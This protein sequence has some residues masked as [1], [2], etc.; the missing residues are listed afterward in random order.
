[1]RRLL[2][3]LLLALAGAVAM[4]P[5]TAQDRP[6]PV[7]K[8][9]VLGPPE[10]W[11]ARHPFPELPEAAAPDSAAV[12]PQPSLTEPFAIGEALHDP[13]RVA[14]A[15]VSALALMGIQIVADDP[16]TITIGQVPMQL[17]QSEVRALITMGVAD[18]EAQ[19]QTPDGP[20][21]FKN[22][23]TRLSRYLGNTSPERLAEM[24]SEE[25][26]RRPESLVPQLLLG[27][28]IDVDTPL[29][30]TELWLMLVDA[31]VPT[32]ASR[33]AARLGPRL[34]LARYAPQSSG[35]GAWLQPT[36]HLPGRMSYFAESQLTLRMPLLLMSTVLLT[37]GSGH[38]GHGG[39]GTTVN[40]QARLRAPTIVATM[41]GGGTV[42]VAK[43]RQSTLAGIPITWTTDNPIRKHAP[44]APPSR[45][46]TVAA[47][48]SARLSFTL[49]AEARTPP[50]GGVMRET[51]FVGLRLDLE[52][53]A[54][55]IYGLFAT[56]FEANPT[57]DL[58]TPVKMQWHGAEI[59]FTIS[60]GYDV[61][62]LGLTRTGLDMALGTLARG[63]DGN[64]HGF[65]DLVAA[66]TMRLPG[67]DCA[68][69]GFGW[70]SAA[71]VGVPIRETVTSPNQ[72]AGAFFNGIRSQAGY[73]LNI[74]QGRPALYL[75]LEFYPTTPPV[76]DPWDDCQ[77]EIPG[78]Q[79]RSTPN[80]VPLN[81]A[82]W[83]IE[84]GYGYG[85]ADTGGGTNQAN[86]AGYA[87]AVA[88]AT[89]PQPVTMVYEERRSPE[90]RRTLQDGGLDRFVKADSTWY[91]TVTHTKPN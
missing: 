55:R 44:G 23:H 75:R 8:P 74:L 45:T 9:P 31:M 62:G 34:A 59:E 71:V 41:P 81:D 69:Y 66:S 56:D 40:I 37:R 22:L 90:N 6:R 18:A 24:F 68:P 64:Y 19:G 89:G 43:P 63:D 73:T 21:T 46:D 67:K 7:G 79:S 33:Q 77:E 88:L 4:Q 3:G 30:R 11:P 78:P 42:L 57:L 39:P 76:Y 15:V 54:S 48:G 83:T 51:G 53:I 25:Y 84:G 13:R 72:R 61:G 28:P 12:L 58:Q 47:D 60:N 32:A 85:G 26:Q 70:Q 27:Q 86:R 52:E 82:Q 20:F 16:N 2:G 38:E 5:A 87:I 10:G 50:R 65:A 91:V 17:T 36:M 35:G 49:K 1:M 14:D 80:F 29:L